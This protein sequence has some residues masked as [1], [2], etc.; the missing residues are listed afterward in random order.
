[1]SHNHDHNHD[2]G[3]SHNHSKDIQNINVLLIAFGLTFIFMIAEF[4]G[5]FFSKSLALMSDAGHMLSDVVSMGV[6]IWAI[7]AGSKTSD[8]SKTFGYK[9]T[10][11]IVA[12]VNGITLVAISIFI[13]FEGFKRIF[14]PVSIHENQLILVSSLGFI[15]NIIVAFILFK[16][17][18]D[19]INV[20]GAFLHVISDLLGSVGAIGAGLIIKYTGWLYADPLISI[21]ISILILRSSIGLIKETYH[22]LMEG[23][24]KNIDFKKVIDKVK[25]FDKVIDIHDLHIWSLNESQII[26]T[27]HILIEENSDNKKIISDIKHLLQHDFNIQHSTIEI[28]T[29]KCEDNCSL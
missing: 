13:M 16:N 11:V 2:H 12:F 18:K 20:R 26:L 25:S 3:Y 17:S 8:L 23:S 5:G 4:V 9:R 14:S 24:P 27:A 15:I 28:E 22:T 29:T 6:A 19:S 1:M 7:K 10:E 21:I